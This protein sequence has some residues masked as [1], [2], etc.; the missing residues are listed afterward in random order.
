MLEQVESGALTDET[1]ANFEFALGKAFEDR[2]DF[3]RA[4]DFYA[5]GNDNRRQRESYDPVQTADVHDQFISTFSKDFL[6]S[7]G[8]RGNPSDAPIGKLTPKVVQNSCMPV[9]ASEGLESRS[10]PMMVA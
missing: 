5:A 9:I 8:G 2:K 1:R 3:D 10:S 6:A 4:F 7:R